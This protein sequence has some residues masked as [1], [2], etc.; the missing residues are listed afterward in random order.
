MLNVNLELAG[1]KRMLKLNELEE[2][3]HKAY[4]S[5]QIYNEKT[6]VWHDKHLV[7]TE[8]KLGQQVLLFNYRLKLF[9]RKLKSKW[10]EPFVIT[11]VFPYGSVELTHP[12]KGTF[13][14]SG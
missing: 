11:Q 10:S 6:K 7:K 3:R 2:F 14:V 8:F 12:E 1:K 13:K 4:E 5:S 9:Q